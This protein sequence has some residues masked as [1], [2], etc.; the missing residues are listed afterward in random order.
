MLLLHKKTFLPYRTI[1]CCSVVR[2][3]RAFFN[4]AHSFKHIA[5]LK[6]IL[7]VNNTVLNIVQKH[8]L[9]EKGHCCFERRAT[10]LEMHIALLQRAWCNL[11]QYFM[12]CLDIV[13]AKTHCIAPEEGYSYSEEHVCLEYCICWQ[14]WGCCN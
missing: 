10:H 13:P 11:K 9:F 2:N 6:G 7:Y 4:S 1:F 8:W 3:T 12:S 14:V 5:L